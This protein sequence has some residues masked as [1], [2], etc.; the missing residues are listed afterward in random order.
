MTGFFVNIGER[1]NVTGSSKFRK[2]IEAEDYSAAVEVARQ[3]VENGA[4]IID[5]NMDEGMLDSEA[6]MI[7]FLRM[8]ASEP[9]ISRVPVMIDSSKWTVIESG[10]KNVQGKSIVN[11]ISLKEGE[12]VF[13]DQAQTLQRYGA[14]TVVMA[15]DESGQ[16]ETA[17]RKF[18]ICSRAYSLL[19]N[20]LEFPPEDII[21]D[22]NIF[23]VATGIE[24]HNGYALAFLEA[25]RRIRSELPHCHVSG[26]LSNLSFSFRG[27][28]TVR[29]AM[30]SAFLFHATKA[31]MNMG[32]VNAGQLDLY[33]EIEK[34]LLERV[35]DVL[36]NRR[37]DATD[38]L[39]EIADS[40]QGKSKITK[41][42]DLSWRQGSASERINYALVHGLN[43]YIIQD[44][45][46]ARNSAERALHVIEGPLMDGMNAVGELFG[47]GKMF[48]PQVVKSARVM[49]QAVGHL[50]PFMEQERGNDT[51]KKKNAG[52]I[53]LATVKGDVH[54]IGKNI[55]GVVL[56]CN[57]Y[58]VIDL[59]VMVPAGKILKVAQDQ[60][61]DAIGLSGLITPSLDEM[62]H[63]ASEMTRQG[64][65][66][67]LLIGGA[68]TSIL[69]TAV[70][71]SP[72]Y[73]NS[74]VHVPDASK[75]VGVV[76]A[77]LTNNKKVAFSKEISEKYASLRETHSK[78]QRER[79]LASIKVA[80]DNRLNLNFSSEPPVK[81]IQPGRHVFNTFSLEKLASFI[82]WTP[83]FKTWDLK[84]KYPSILNDKKVGMAATQL[85]NDAQEMLDKITF[86]NW[87]E[88]KAVVDIW[89][90][91]RINYDDIIIY[92]NEF[93]DKPIA[94][95]HML[96]QQ[97]LRDNQKYNLSL[98]DFIA[99]TDAGIADW[100]GGFVVTMG[101]G[102][103]TKAK[104]F[105]KK[106]DDYS[107]IMVKALGDRLA[108][109]FAEQMHLK[110]RKEIWGYQTMENLNN[111]ALIAEQYSGI[112]PAPGYPAC[113]DHTEKNIL[114]Q[115]LDA[116]NL[117]GVKLTENFAMLPA[118]TVSG[119]YFAHPKSRYFGVGKI[120]FDQ[121]KDYAKRKQKPASEIERWLSPN[122][123][124]DINN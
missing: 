104:I 26:G 100:L 64:F 16:A 43:E 97:M 88:P 24:E 75:A 124:Y 36:L 7:R 49:K 60:K 96:R 82:D 54:D 71:I 52:K 77:L 58:E 92:A 105:E 3:Q 117:T 109:A 61:V 37:K 57:D 103:D 106:H 72:S 11:S 80:R 112:R 74:V 65:K 68:T 21:F 123:G 83:F 56:Q 62:C 63:V 34:D 46:E 38:R 70:K 29:R 47:A 69:H 110:V 8:I 94:T 6:A 17:D 118:S 93:R 51:E 18:E 79:N 66:I 59:G 120:G 81:P 19:T 25:T 12:S 45:E 122:L 14:A 28:E 115:L 44:T 35:E 78:G 10:L 76:N 67:P 27:N 113:P 87:F 40:F 32:I 1:T 116:T 84:G 15:F 85:H 89:P 30:H 114:F 53:L 111:E 101:D 50:I 73:N 107:A 121:V 42:V 99:P 22:P 95:F 5:V 102:P 23:A 13:L 90:A 31:G 86:E 41:G 2:L 39:L 20:K 48:L 91:N 98:A 119:L 9:D 55:V 108:E 4:Q 33:E